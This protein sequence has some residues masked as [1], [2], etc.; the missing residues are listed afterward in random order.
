MSDKA[1][2]SHDKPVDPSIPFHGFPTDPVVLG[3]P[4]AIRLRGVG[5]PDP[6]HPPEPDS[7]DNPEPT[8]EP[9]SELALATFVYGQWQLEFGA[10]GSVETFSLMGAAQYEARRR[11]IHE[12]MMRRGQEAAVDSRK[13]RR[14]PILD[15]IET[16]QRSL[17]IWTIVRDDDFEPGEG[18]Q[19]DYPALL[20]DLD[21]KATPRN[22][23]P[24]GEVHEFVF[25][26]NRAVAS[27]RYKEL[28][29]KYFQR[30]RIAESNLDAAEYRR[31]DDR[32]KKAT[33]RLK[34][35]IS[36]RIDRLV[37][38]I[39]QAEKE[40]AADDAQPDRPFAW[41]VETEE[42]R[43][44]S[45]Y[46]AEAEAGVRRYLKMFDDHRRRVIRTDLRRQQL[47]NR[48]GG[49]TMYVG[50]TEVKV[51]PRYQVMSPRQRILHLIAEFEHDLHFYPE[52]QEG[53]DTY[54]RKIE[55]RVYSE[56]FAN[57]MKWRKTQPDGRTD[58]LKGSQRPSET[59]PKDPPTG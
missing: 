1:H 14:Q 53:S 10:E 37:A 28:H 7:P 6:E 3:D 27:P 51:P 57:F 52:Y 17:R 33:E 43:K 38:A 26:H 36:G 48:I 56:E 54:V 44:F 24:T 21:P 2:D 11:V 5:D 18:L 40:L 30:K 13:Y 31:L 39:Q 58:G 12:T 35:W 50:G 25:L 42:G 23:G 4:Y 16:L 55:Q 20:R 9:A 49:E 59:G 19:V 32:L 22:I 45:R 46:H 8:A 29:K 47:Y 15:R 34:E 41:E